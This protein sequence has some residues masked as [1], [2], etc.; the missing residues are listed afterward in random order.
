MN[1]ADV[2]ISWSIIDSKKTNFCG[3]SRKGV[4]YNIIIM[5]HTILIG[6]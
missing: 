4:R 2:S 5:S 6:S 1:L 3:G